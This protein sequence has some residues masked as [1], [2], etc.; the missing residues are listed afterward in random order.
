MKKLNIITVIGLLLAGCG[1]SKDHARVEPKPF[2]PDYTAYVRVL[3]TFVQGELVD[4]A[5]L[6]EDRS[7]LDQF[8]SELAGLSLEEYD[9]MDATEQMA[10]WLNAY[11]GITLRSVIDAYPVASIKDIEGVWD[12]TRWTVAGENVTLDDIEHNILR[13][14]YEDG[15]IHFAVNCA[16]LGCPPLLAEPFLPEVLDDQLD[17]LVFAFV[18]DVSRNSINPHNNTLTTTEIFSW[19]GDDF[20]DEFETDAYPNLRPAE[21]AVLNFIFS[22]AD[23]S[24]LEFVDESAEWTIE[25]MPYDWSLNDIK[26]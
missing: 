2:D 23:E 3:N 13:P 8:V 21:A 5:R 11:N 7:D 10:L 9:E 12:K 19:F 14:V 18:N 25:Y 26:R 16:S 15:R 1:S 24:I 4:Y 20:R 17:D 22:Y 6:K